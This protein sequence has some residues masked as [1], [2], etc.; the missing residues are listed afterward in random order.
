[1][2]LAAVTVV[3][4][5]SVEQPVVQTL[6]PHLEAV[7][8][9]AS[10]AGDGV[11]SCPFPS[12][13]RLYSSGMERV[14]IADGQLAG[15]VSTEW[16]SASL[17]APWSSDIRDGDDVL[18]YMRC[19]RLPVAIVE[20]QGA[21]PGGIATCTISSPTD[22]WRWTP[23]ERPLIPTFS[24][25]PDPDPYSA[26]L[27]AVPMSAEARALVQSW[28]HSFFLIRSAPPPDAMLDLDGALLRRSL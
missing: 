19:I 8:A 13:G 12:S 11:I 14:E 23:S 9:V 18:E 15:W 24:R 20:W 28:R 5:S 10:V 22:D 17:Y 21:I 7:V 2:A 1:M 25:R 26:A 27:E 3:G 16:G 4:G 6:P